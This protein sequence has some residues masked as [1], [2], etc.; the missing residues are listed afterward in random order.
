MRT[1]VN[2][3]YQ[4]TIATVTEDYWMGPKWALAFVCFSFL[5]ILFFGFGYV[6]VRLS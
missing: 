1:A 6:C 2:I 3:Y 5:F 4:S